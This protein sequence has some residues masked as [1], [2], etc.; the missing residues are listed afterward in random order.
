LKISTLFM[1]RQMYHTHRFRTL[2]QGLLPGTYLLE[3][4]LLVVAK[5]FWTHAILIVVSQQPRDLLAPTSRERMG[6]EFHIRLASEKTFEQ[7]T[8]EPSIICVLISSMSQVTYFRC[9]AARRG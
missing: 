6:K 1:H 2:A 8:C 7:M 4:S 9:V 5:F 3:H